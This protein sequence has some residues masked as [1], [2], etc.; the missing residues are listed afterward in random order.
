MAAGLVPTT[1]TPASA[2]RLANPSG[3]CPPSCTI[4]PTTPGPPR[5]DSDSAWYTSSTSSNVSGSK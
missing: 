2:R 5:P 1:G 3:V 4:T